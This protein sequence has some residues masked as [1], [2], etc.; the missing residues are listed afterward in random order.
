MDSVIQHGSSSGYIHDG[1]DFLIAQQ[2]LQAVADMLAS[3]TFQTSQPAD[4]LTKPGTAASLDLY[5]DLLS[6][7]GT[8]PQTRQLFPGIGA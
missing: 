5:G 2:H 6:G 4:L 8:C 1:P 7:V 3:T